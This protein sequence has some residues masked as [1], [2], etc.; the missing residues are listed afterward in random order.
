MPWAM[1]KGC[2]LGEC[3]PHHLL[4]GPWQLLN[5][6]DKSLPHEFLDLRSRDRRQIPPVRHHLQPILQPLYDVHDARFHAIWPVVG[7]DPEIAIIGERHGVVNR[8]LGLRGWGGG[9][10][11]LPLKAFKDDVGRDGA[12]GS[13]NS[14]GLFYVASVRKLTNE[15]VQGGGTVG[16]LLLQGLVPLVVL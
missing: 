16:T 14:T 10:Q 4:P 6:V 3:L 12:V 11:R 1:T 9:G 13:L 8:E 2:L 5:P 7:Q 15:T